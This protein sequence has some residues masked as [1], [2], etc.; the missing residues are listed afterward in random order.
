MTMS[1]IGELE[2]PV[3][4]LF[5]VPVYRVSEERYWADVLP[6]VETWSRSYLDRRLSAGASPTTTDR[7]HADSWARYALKVTDWRY[8]QVLAWAR[9]YWDGPGPVVKCYGWIVGDLGLDGA[10]VRARYGRNFKPYPYVFGDPTWKLFENWF[11]DEDSDRDIFDQL[12]RSLLSVTRTEGR[13]L[14]G[15]HVDLSAFDEVGR[16]VRWRQVI[17]LEEAGA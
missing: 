14:R 7:V 17:G 8:N 11:S 16:Y 12:R 13:P 3:R 1:D 9:L 4:P 2:S 15:R 6:A 5:E 10:A